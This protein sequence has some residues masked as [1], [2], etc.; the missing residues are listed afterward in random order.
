MQP[1]SDISLCE[2]IQIN[3]AN[4][5]AIGI[6]QIR[7]VWQCTCKEINIILNFN[8]LIFILT[9]TVTS[10]G[11]NKNTREMRVEHEMRVIHEMRVKH[12]RCV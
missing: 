2:I 10:R 1:G 7:L 12:E 11:K 6:Q 4:V 3:G 9:N 8:N 5:C